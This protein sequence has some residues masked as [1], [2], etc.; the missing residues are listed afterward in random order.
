M[1]VEL[2]AVPPDGHPR[3]E[4]LTM[5]AGRILVAHAPAYATKEARMALAEQLSEVIG[6]DCEHVV[7]LPHGYK[8]EILEPVEAP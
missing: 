8:L 4:M 5:E 2:R 6:V 1:K 7:V 3:G